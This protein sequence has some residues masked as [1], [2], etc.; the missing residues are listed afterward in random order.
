MARPDQHTRSQF[1]RLVATVG[2][3]VTLFTAGAVGLTVGSASADSLTQQIADAQKQLDAL[4]AQAE[5]ASERYNAAR[6]A[7]LA[8]QR[9]VASAEQRLTQAQSRLTGLR[10]TV[11][12][13][14]V[15]AYTGSSLDD[16]LGISAT[17]PTEYLDK[18]SMLQAVSSRQDEVL[19]SV[20]SAQRDQA[21][22]QASADA[23]LAAQQASTRQMQAERDVVLAAAGKER[24][25]LHTLQV[26]EAAAIRAAKA[27]AAKAAAERAAQALQ[28]R[29]DAAAAAARA[30]AS[31]SVS[32]TPVV[33]GS[34]GARVA[35]EW[36]Y[37]ELGKPYVWGAAGPDSFDC[38]GLT[39]YVWAKAGVYLDHYTGAQ[40]NEGRHVS[41][42]D[43]QP[44]DLV[45]FGSDLH[46]V[47]IYIGNGNMIE[48]PHSGANV[49]IAGA[50][51]SDYAG[52][53]RPGT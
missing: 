51:R 26:R 37:K 40:W 4:D 41:R 24:A 27:A 6:I 49:R 7:Q 8:A 20:S 18:L 33:S 30:L 2:V 1:F 14:A 19:A 5:A 32:S 53:I 52:A 29:A 13:F 47:G 15:A 46:H 39:Q 11:G 35:V 43:L 17:D 38:S 48:A 31:Q 10:K 9:N 44:G 34:G 50:F 21:A 22:A 42:G 25:I 12:A 28:A 23:A 45:F 16:S 36:A 3:A